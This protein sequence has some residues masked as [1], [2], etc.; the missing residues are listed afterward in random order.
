MIRSFKCSE[1]QGLYERHSSRRLPPSIQRAALR[2]LWMLDAAVDLAELRVP[3]GN[4]LEA[5]RGDRAGQHSIR[6]NQQWRIC[7]RWHQG[8]AFDVEIVDDH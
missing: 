8:H 5:L 3:P 7:F 6:I 4:R 2:K 1:T